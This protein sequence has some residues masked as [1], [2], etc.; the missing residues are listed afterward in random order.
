MSMQIS[1]MPHIFRNIR[2]VHLADIIINHMN[3]R[4]NDVV[5]V[6]PSLHNL[7]NCDFQPEDLIYLLK[8]I[9]G[10][11][12]TLLMPVFGKINLTQI[13]TQPQH[14]KQDPFWGNDLISEAFQDM[15]DTIRVN[16][17]G[18]TLAAWGKHAN[19]MA[20][21]INNTNLNL[22]KVSLGYKLNQLKAKF[23]GLGMPFK[24]K[25]FKKYSNQA[26]SKTLSPKYTNKVNNE[27]VELILDLFKE[28]EFK[29]FT[30]QGISF[31]WIESEKE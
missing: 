13:N 7:N 2:L 8:M 30:K 6:H 23:I 11:E 22:D 10:T 1:E 24:K 16:Y 31:I 17:P 28:N 19:S 12:G 25:L 20:E 3:I 18:Y 14:D 26:K 4:R 5:M 9:I 15:P 29:M 21:T 27:S